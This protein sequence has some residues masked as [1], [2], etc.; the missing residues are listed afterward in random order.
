VHRDAGRFAIDEKKR[1]A[2]GVMAASAVRAD[3]TSMS[4]CSP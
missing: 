4:A 1:E 2:I 3:T